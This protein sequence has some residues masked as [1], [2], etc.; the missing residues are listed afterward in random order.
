MKDDSISPYLAE[1]RTRPAIERRAASIHIHIDGDKG[2]SAD[3]VSGACLR[4]LYSLLEHV[5]GYQ[6]GQI[7]RSSFDNIEAL[8][9]WSHTEQCCWFALKAAE[10]AQYQYRYAVPTLLV[11]RFL[12][13]QDTPKSSAMYMALGNMVAT[14]F[15]SSIPVISLATSD[16]LSNLMAVVVR[17]TATDAKDELL[18]VLV[19][20]ISSLGRHVYYSDQIQDL[21]VCVFLNWHLFL[22]QQLLSR[23]KLSLDLSISKRMASCRQTILPTRTLDRRHCGA[24]Y[25]DFLASCMLQAR[26]KPWPP[27]LMGQGSDQILRRSRILLQQIM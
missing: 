27:L 22:S 25:Q 16:I 15:N 2:P 1:F 9:S 12:E 14:V 17:R 24:W 8:N 5:N 19:N 18:P 26:M 7:M 4:A 20:C 21:S 11:D 3:E 6:L 23:R 13:G 10:W